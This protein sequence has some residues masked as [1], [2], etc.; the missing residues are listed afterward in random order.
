MKKFIVVIATLLVF[1]SIASAEVIGTLGLND[2]NVQ[3]RNSV[4]AHVFDAGLDDG[5]F[6]LR[7]EFQ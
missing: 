4:L 5:R 6:S 1:A 3:A 2:S 7:L